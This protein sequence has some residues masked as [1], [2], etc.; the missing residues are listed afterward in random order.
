MRNIKIVR[1]GDGTGQLV[2]TL[3]DVELEETAAAMQAFLDLQ[4]RPRAGDESSA[5]DCEAPMEEPTR[6]AR[7]ADAFMDLVRTALTHADD[8]HAGGDDRYMVHVVERPGYPT[9][10]LDG[11]PIDPADAA[12]IRCD[13]AQVTHV[14]GEGGETLRLG[15]KTRDWSTAQRR[16]I[17]VRDGGRCRFFGCDHRHYDIHH[18]EWWERGGPTDIDNGC[19]Q[20]RRHHRMLHQGYRVEG[21]PESELKFY[22][23]N[24]RYIG[25]TYPATARQLLPV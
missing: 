8:G 6:A 24:G 4:F 18:L 1:G 15:R 9:T 10:F 22:R 25:S 5:E 7:Q 12:A 16:A 21:D 17:A 13:C 11:R 23:P 20:C 14:T 19:T 3:S 2:V